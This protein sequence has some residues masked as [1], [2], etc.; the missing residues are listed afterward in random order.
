MATKLLLIDPIETFIKVTEESLY[1]EKIFDTVGANYTK[2]L[3]SSGSGLISLNTDAETV[4]ERLK[5]ERKQYGAK[6]VFV[7]PYNRDSVKTILDFYNFPTKHLYSFAASVNRRD[8]AFRDILE[9]F[10][11]EAGECTMVSA[12][13]KE[14]EEAKAFGYRT[15]FFDRSGRLST[16]ETDPVIHH[17]H[18]ISFTL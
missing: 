4:M 10:E 14:I 12:F 9:Y 7:S 8:V 15:V 2:T 6:I 5:E 3:L 17:L 13:R 1:R 11:V 18:E 16:K